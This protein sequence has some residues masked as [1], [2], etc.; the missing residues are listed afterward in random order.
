[1]IGARIDPG[2]RRPKPNGDNSAIDW[3]VYN[4]G[5]DLRPVPPRGWLILGTFCRKFLSLLI[6]RGGTGKTAVRIAQAMAVATGIEI[7]Q[8]KV[9]V[10][11]NV[12]YVS[13]EDDVEEMQRRLEATRLRFGI[14]DEQL[15]DALY[16]A[17]P[18]GAQLVK[19]NERTGAIEDEGDL[20]FWLER[21]IVQYRVGLV[22]I[23]PFVKAAGVPEND[24][25]AID[26]VCALLIKLA[27]DQD[28]AIDVLHHVAKGFVEAGDSDKA[29]GASA[30][31]DA[32][33][34]V[35][36]LLPMTGADAKKYHCESQQSSLLRLDL[37][38][39]NITPKLGDTL[40][41]K[42]IGVPLNNGTELYPAGDTLQVAEP[43]SPPDHWDLIK[44]LEEAIL[45]KLDLGPGNNRRYTASSQAGAKRAAWKV[46]FDT[47]S[48]GKLSQGQCQA[49][50]N[51]W[52]AGG[53]LLSCRYRDP[54]ER[55]HV[56]GLYR[57]GGKVPPP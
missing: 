37:G 18:L 12:L 52:V 33:R 53:A 35:S 4:A 5:T 57:R 19:F 41:F 50:I 15:L 51:D 44:P 13:L 29:R 24:N 42:L 43:W 22:V 7:T 25:A 45:S 54:I 17:C 48:D 14:S 49:T 31:R 38:K 10:R 56:L 6:A 34:L 39:A 40:W 46:V 55:K 9:F 3:P 47:I 28:C 2:R 16:F 26:R 32:A 21:K 11:C 27:S 30:L 36:T 20:Y 23:D 8:Q 1:M